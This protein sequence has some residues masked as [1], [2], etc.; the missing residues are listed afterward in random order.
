[1]L[2]LKLPSYI[3]ITPIF[4][5]KDSPWP[6]IASMG[7]FFIVTGTVFLFHKNI[8][9]ILLFGVTFLLLSMFQWSRDL[10]RERRMVGG[11]TKFFQKALKIGMLLF[12]LSEVIFFA[13]FFWRFFHRRTVPCV[14]IGVV[15][16][17]FGITAINPYGIPLLN[18]VILLSSG[19]SVTWSHHRLQKNNFNQSFVSLVLTCLLGWF[20]LK[21]QLNEYIN[22][23][24]TFADRVFGRV[25]FIATGFHGLHVLIGSV[26]LT[27]AGLR[28]FFH[29][30]SNGHHVGYEAA[31]WYW[32]FV[33]VVW[34]FL[35]C[36]I[37]F[38]G[39]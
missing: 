8:I 23:S 36:F 12:I 19:V 32:H 27:I 24:F 18:T 31:I 26:I 3:K 14:E 29:H 10:V 6:I 1:L 28:M 16:P 20:F 7:G 25:F 9:S 21:I 35:F 13:S 22:S 33:D 17:P 11:H 2:V 38:W 4:L 39:Y 15:W 5:L 34:L 37:Y 30:F